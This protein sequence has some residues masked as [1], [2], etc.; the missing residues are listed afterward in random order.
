MSK[1]LGL[2]PHSA[3]TLVVKPTH[4]RIKWLNNIFCNSLKLLYPHFQ[5]LLL[6][7]SWLIKMRHSC[8]APLATCGGVMQE[9]QLLSVS[10]RVAGSSL[11]KVR[12]FCK[13]LNVFLQKDKNTGEN[14]IKIFSIISSFLLLMRLFPLAFY[15]PNSLL[16]LLFKL[17]EL[18]HKSVHC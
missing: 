3:R 13:N 16:A 9:E 2:R 12:L 18:K 4:K 14:K 17:I 5:Y 1:T 15:F 7:D 11:S 8:P 10:A 6:W